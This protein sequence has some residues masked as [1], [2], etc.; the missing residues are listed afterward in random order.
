MADQDDV[1]RIALSLPGTREESGR[2]AFTVE[3]KGKQRPGAAWRRRGSRRTVRAL[4]AGS[5]PERE[6]IA[7]KERAG[8]SCRP[9][10]RAL[11][12]RVRGG[13]TAA[14][15]RGLVRPDGPAAVSVPSWRATRIEPL[16]ALR[17]R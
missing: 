5:A 6:R 12:V 11:L 3:N 10:P 8:I 16:A 17:E 1:R 7:K 2:F 13:G 4:A 9:F 15:R 14:D